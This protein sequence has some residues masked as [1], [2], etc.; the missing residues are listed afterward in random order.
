MSWR[1][2]L[3]IIGLSIGLVLFLRQ[4]WVGIRE[5]QQ[6]DL[7]LTRPGYL[8]AALGAGILMYTLQMLAWASI[9]RAL[10]V[11]LGLRQTFSGYTLSFLPRYIPGTVWG[12]WT[13]SEWLERSYGVDY[14]V[15]G[16]GSVLEAFGAVLTGLFMAGMAFST[17]LKGSAQLLMIVVCIGLLVVS[18]VAAPWLIT[19]IGR[20]SWA[21]SS[22]QQRGFGLRSKAWSVSIALYV[23][24]WLTFGVMLL[25]VANSMTAV[26]IAKLPA[27]VFAASSSWVIGF[28]TIIVPTGLG[29]R[30]LAL[31]TLLSSYGGFL[32]WQADVIAV[33]SRFAIVLA[34]LAWLLVGLVLYGRE[35]WKRSVC[36]PPAGASGEE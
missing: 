15:S 12:Y 16:T 19:R 32:P 23:G 35:R 11:S 24:L 1:R 17:Q 34:E 29:V 14:A 22:T 28:V 4:T 5:I 27:S 33:V 25:L 3:F 2:R 31:S 26:P 10:G 13:R 6:H 36:V 30:E 9:M 18:W 8:L 21:K 20:R 7:G